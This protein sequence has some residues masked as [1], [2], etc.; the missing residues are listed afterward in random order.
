MQIGIYKIYCSRLC[1]LFIELSTIF[2]FFFLWPAIVLSISLQESFENTKGVIK[3]RKWMVRDYNGQKD[4]QWY[5]KQYT[6]K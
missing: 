6:E 3:N 1:F 5:R 2:V 4:I